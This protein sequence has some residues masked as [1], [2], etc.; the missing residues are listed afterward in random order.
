[1]SLSNLS[2]LVIVVKFVHSCKQQF[3]S[4]ANCM[5]QTGFFLLAVRI[6]TVLLLLHPKRYQW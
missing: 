5:V 6:S 2:V 3:N 1:M 4:H